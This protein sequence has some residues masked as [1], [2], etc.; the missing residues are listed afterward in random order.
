[1]YFVKKISTLFIAIVC[2]LKDK[3]GSIFFPKTLHTN[4]HTL[5]NMAFFFLFFLPF[6]FVVFFWVNG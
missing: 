5:E 6:F 2:F 1:M 4:T 3:R